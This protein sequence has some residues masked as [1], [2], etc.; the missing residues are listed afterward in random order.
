MYIPPFQ[1]G[2]FVGAVTVL[3]LEIVAVM[4][5]NY[6]SKKKRRELKK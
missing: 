3:G 4:I 2:I 1:L 5:D 6:K